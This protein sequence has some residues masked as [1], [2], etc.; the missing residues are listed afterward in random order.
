MVQGEDNDTKQQCS[1]FETDIYSIL[2][3]DLADIV[4]IQSILQQFRINSPETLF[5]INSKET[6]KI[7]YDNTP[8]F[9]RPEITNYWNGLKNSPIFQEKVLQ[10]KIVVIGEKIIFDFE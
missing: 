10:G 6:L 4:P 5:R 2:K 3:D 8:V 7:I 9:I 1:K